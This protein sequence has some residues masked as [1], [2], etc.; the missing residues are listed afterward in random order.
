G[1]GA[2]LLTN[3]QAADNPFFRLG[4]AW[5]TLPLVLLST[6]AT[7]IASQALISGAFSLSM[8]AMHMGY[9]PRMRVTYTSE[10]HAG[11]VYMPGINVALMVA[12][13]GL[14]VG[15]RTS[16]NLAAAYGVAVTTTMVVTTA[17]F[18]A[19]ARERFGWSRA[20]ALTACGV[21]LVV[22][23]AFFTGNLFKIP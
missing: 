11:Q 23:L 7:V 19:V 21:F 22:D 8:Q 4:P 17:L 5:T 3:P 18:Y 12:C 10:R 9:L 2:L 14:V 16:G 13:I 1:Q 6:A 15:F 20:T